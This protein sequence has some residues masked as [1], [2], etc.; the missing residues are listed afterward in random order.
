MEKTGDPSYTLALPA[1]SGKY[2][3]LLPTLQPGL[4][5]FFHLRGATPIGATTSAL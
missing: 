3:L 1:A 5:L 4:A 2:W